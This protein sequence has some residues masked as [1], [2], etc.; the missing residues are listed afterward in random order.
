M[1]M[2]AGFEELIE[3]TEF[4]KEV[5][6]LIN[7]QHFLIVFVSLLEDEDRMQITPYQERV[8]EASLLLIHFM[9]RCERINTRP[10][11]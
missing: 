1:H 9:S 11:I 6:Y 2:L 5:I 7:N 3:M 8:V 10:E 4:Q